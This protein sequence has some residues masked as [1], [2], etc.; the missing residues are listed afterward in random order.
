MR[1]KAS[2]WRWLAVVAVFAVVAVACDTGAEEP[3]TV[4]TETTAGPATTQAPTQTQPP[5]AAPTGFTYTMGVISD[6][7][8]D[9]V[10]HFYDTESDVYNSYLLNAQPAFL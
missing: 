6:F 4:A 10:W 2:L 9:N 1:S 8:T 7:T 5:T 3:T